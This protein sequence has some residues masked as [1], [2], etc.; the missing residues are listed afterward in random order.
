[1][2]TITNAQIKKAISLIAFEPELRSLTD[3]LANIAKNADHANRDEIDLVDLN[4]CIASCIWS[5]E[6]IIYDL[7]DKGY[8]ITNQN[9][10]AILSEIDRS[11]MESEMITVG[12]D[13]IHG[14]R[15]NAEKQNK[16]NK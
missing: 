8:K 4:G 5:N 12:W 2:H 13:Y 16:L 11:D 10:D 1:M 14:A 3:A 6:D 7:E 15:D 9:I